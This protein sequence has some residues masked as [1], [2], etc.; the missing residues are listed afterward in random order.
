MI[1]PPEAYEILR[2]CPA[3]ENVTRTRR[4][5][6]NATQIGNTLCDMKA[7][8]LVALNKVY[9]T[10]ETAESECSNQSWLLF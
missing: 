10:D 6:S 3:V 2:C 9:L 8:S 4:S 1:I 5:K 7:K